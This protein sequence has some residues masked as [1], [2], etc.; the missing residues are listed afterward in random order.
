MGRQPEARRARAP[1]ARRRGRWH[2][3][4]RQVSTRGDS[5]IGRRLRE[6]EAQRALLESGMR[7]G[8]LLALLA[9]CGDSA[10][11]GRDGGGDVDTESDV[12]SDSDGDSDS[13]ADSDSESGTE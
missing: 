9:C 2:A 4:A 12:A 8:A 3:P 13:D 10:R 6:R 5:T 7:L 1:I 11:D